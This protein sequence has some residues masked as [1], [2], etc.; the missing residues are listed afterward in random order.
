L[1]ALALV[2]AGC[3]QELKSLSDLNV[4]RNAL[5]EKYEHGEINVTVQN[6]T[7]LGIQFINSRFNA[8]D[9]AGRRAKAQEI[10]LFARAHFPSISRIT[11]IWIAFLSGETRLYV[12][13]SY[14][15][16]GVFAFDKDRIE[17]GDLDT[18]YERAAASRSGSGA[19]EF[20]AVATYDEPRDQ[21]TVSVNHLQLYGT[22]DDGLVLLPEFVV[23]G[24]KIKPPEWVDF[25]FVS[26]SKRPVFTE[27]RRLTLFADGAKVT[28]KKPRLST[29]GQ[30]VD[31]TYSEVISHRLSY[32]EF[33]RLVNGG[34]AKLQLGAKEIELSAAHLRLLREMKDCVDEARCP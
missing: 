22:L 32:K 19:E 8:L 11:R 5:A 7:Y 1:L 3:A 23:S 2:V 30:G 9:D 17:A 12:F 18:L 13:H 10:A 31:G 26:Y 21:T 14:E 25:E 27:D 20:K 34:D 29:T 15:T 16:R 24:R 4:L 28:T 33:L 6:G